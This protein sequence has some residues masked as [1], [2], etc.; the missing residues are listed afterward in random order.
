MAVTPVSFTPPVMDR[1]FLVREADGLR[2]RDQIWVSVGATELPSGSVLAGPIT[3]KGATDVAANIYT[4][5]NPSGVAGAATVAGLLLDGTR[6]NPYTGTGVPHKAS[7]RI[8]F[9]DQPTNDTT[10]T[11]NGEALTFK[12]SGASGEGQVNKGADLE[13]T[14]VAAAAKLNAATT[15]TAWT[16]ATYYATATTLEIVHDTAGTGGND[17]TV[18][19][20]ANSNGTALAATLVGGGNLVQAVIINT[21]AEVKELEIKWFSGASAGQKAT[22]LAALRALGIKARPYSTTQITT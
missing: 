7:G 10:I 19:A 6:S 5:Y 11:L 1:F 21:D 18:V 3:T 22:G 20:G 4:Q 9:S 17:Y 8:T 12:A 14:L 16:V 13:A 15:T 2:S